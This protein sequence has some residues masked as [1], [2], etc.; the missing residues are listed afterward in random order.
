M[1]ALK[2]ITKIIP[3]IAVISLN[4]YAIGAGY[5]MY[6]IQSIAIIVAVILIANLIMA[7]SI[8]LR[9]HFSIG[10][11]VIGV[12]GVI[13]TFVLPSL[14]QLYIENIIAGIYFGLF[15][16]ALI[17]PIFNKKP[18]TVDISK[19]AYPEVIIKSDL[20][21][22]VNNI[23][24]YVW[25][26]L[27]FVAIILTILPYSEDSGIQ[28]ILSTLIPVIP[29]L[30]IGLPVTKYMPDWLNQRVASKRMIFSSLAEA[31]E[32]M[33]FGLN[34]KLAKGID[35]VIQFELTGDEAG[36]AHL[37]IKDQKCEFIQEPHSNPNTI[38]K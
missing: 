14:G 13:S 4:V 1:K 27:F 15:L 38:I 16:V 12:L 32:A 17:P 37:L 28:I 18:F 20:F 2:L 5:R 7:F 8:K 24:S 26:A 29:L 25:A 22:K 33:P 19:G 10:V 9:D 23:M 6:L 31:S 11:S 21:R 34:K 35:T 30:A 36:I 3:F